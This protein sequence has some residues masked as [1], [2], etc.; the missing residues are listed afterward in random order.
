MDQAA[1]PRVEQLGLTASDGQRLAARCYWPAGEVR[2]AVLI[3]PAMAVPQRFYEAFATW[4]AGQGVAVFT[5]DFR[6]MGESA[7]ASLRGFRATITDW[8]TLDLPAVIAAMRARCGDLPLSWLGHSLGGQVFG[9]VPGRERFERM[10]TVAS[11]SGWWFNNS[12]AVRWI[13]HLMWHVTAPV[14]IALAGYFPGERLKQVGN[15]PAGVMWQWRRWCLH[16][17]YLGAEGPQVRALY[18][19]VKTP[20]RAVILEDDELI[21]PSGIRDL[22]RLYS[23]APVQFES[24]RPQAVG[25]KRIGHF[26]LFQKKSADTL[27]PKALSWLAD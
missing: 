13:V 16:R 4:L 20:I 9:M 27:W 3:V 19:A 17:D 26:G 1:S 8:A 21:R 7:P 10:L 2:R 5:F 15:L 18:A 25:L 12:G 6:G 11:G 24:I 14:S 23:G 22:Y